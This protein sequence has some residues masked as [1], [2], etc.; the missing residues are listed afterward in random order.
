MRKVSVPELALN[1]NAILDHVLN[2]RQS[3]LIERDKSVIARLTPET[4]V[5][6]AEQALANFN[7]QT[8]TA[9]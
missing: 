5:M 8:L 2:Q 9:G 4:G 6:T 7:T 3:V 1:T